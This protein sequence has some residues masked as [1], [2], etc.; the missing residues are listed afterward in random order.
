MKQLSIQ[1]DKD[2]LT[3]DTAKSIHLGTNLAK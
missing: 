1:K 2:Y 3:F